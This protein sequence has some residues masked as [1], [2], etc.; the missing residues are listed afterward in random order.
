MRGIRAKLACGV[1][2]ALVALPFVVQSAP[3]DAPDSSADPVPCTQALTPQEAARGFLES[4]PISAAAPDAGALAAA[5]KSE[6]DAVCKSPDVY[7][8]GP[9]YGIARWGCENGYSFRYLCGNN[10]YY[11]EKEVDAGYGYAVVYFV[12]VSP[13]GW[14]VSSL[15]TT[16]PATLMRS[17]DGDVKF[18]VV[19][20][21]RAKSTTAS[22]ASDSYASL[23]KQYHG[24]ATVLKTQIL[25]YCSA[26]KTAYCQE[27]RSL[28]TLLT[29]SAPVATGAPAVRLSIAAKADQHLSATSSLDVSSDAVSL[30]VVTGT[31]LDDQ[32]QPVGNAEVS[33]SGGDIT[34]HTA[35]DGTYH[36]SLFGTGTTLTVRH[37]DLV[38][39][40]AYLTLSIAATGAAQVVG[41]AADGTSQLSVTVTSHGI[42][43]DSVT[44][45]APALGEFSRPSSNASPLVL[46]KDGNG[47]LVYV[48][49]DV[50]PDEL[51]T[52]TVVVGSSDAM[53]QVPAATVPITVKFQDLD[54]VSRTTGLSI[55]VCRPPVVLVQ[56]Y[57]G[58]T[59]SWAR[60]AD[61]AKARRLDCLVVGEGATW[62]SG[63]ASLEEWAKSLAASL[64]AARAAYETTGIRIGAVDVVA[65]SV[66]G[67]VVR[68]LLEGTNPRRDV[69]KLILVGSP[70]HGVAW[71]DQEVGGAATKWLE[72]HAMAAAEV[73]EGSTFL[74]GLQHADPADRKTEYVNIVGRRTSTLSA[75]RQGSSTVQDDGIVSAA[76]AHLD[77]VPDLRFDGVVHAPGL[78]GGTALTESPDVWSQIYGLLIGE[79]PHAD[80]DALKIELRRGQQVST[81]IN[82]Q[83]TPWIPV[84]QYPS[85]L[86]SSMSIRTGDKGYASIA[87]THAGSAWGTISL[88]AKTEVIVRTGMPSL[89]RIEVVSG[90]ARF[91]A[92]DAAANAGD[93]EVVLDPMTRPAAWYMLQ[94]DARIVGVDADFVAAREE[95][96][97]VIAL[98]GTVIVETSDGIGFSP[99]R[100]VETGK[101]IRVRSGGTSEDEAV[102]AH[103]WWTLGVWREPV[104]FF[105]FPPWLMAL[106]LAGLAGAVVYRVLANR[107]LAERSRAKN[108]P[109]GGAT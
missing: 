58:G 11:L 91:H 102:P 22:L 29:R 48:P 8:L 96:D 4:Q 70:N 53:R 37:V 97:S 65:H 41:V 56:S 15:D 28:A 21:L 104:P 108:T 84:A 66:A 26:Y 3:C 100:L 34:T 68:S 12:V 60:F 36:I 95:T 18:A 47:T 92:Q 13:A 40:R 45:V 89:T 54:G 63:N 109:P 35:T 6:A 14:N 77:G 43:T 31:A 69:H 49:P 7:T 30:L 93:F 62:T 32:G 51:L 46:D 74:L 16:A 106:S 42:R 71:L 98:S 67:L 24:Q 61:Y 39:Q 88:D 87:I 99:A 78:V 72:G 55:K 27:L 44:I 23:Q 75:V 9:L 85:T 82:P 59:A 76:S 19:L 1:L 20:S 81:S 105:C 83:V 52:D 86:S 101:G 103:G 90:R 38:L 80:P 17:S 107:R 57:F 94:P 2:V 33:L 10:Y 50:L 73:A 25:D 79:V 5:L 64:S